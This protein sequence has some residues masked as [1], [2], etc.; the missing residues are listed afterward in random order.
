MTRSAPAFNRYLVYP[1]A[2]NVPSIQVPLIGEAVEINEEI[3]TG[4]CEALNV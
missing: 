3:K 2:P 4:M 1:P